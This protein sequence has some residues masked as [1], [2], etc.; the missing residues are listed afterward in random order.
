[1]RCLLFV[2]LLVC[3]SFSSDTTIY[4]NDLPIH[5]EVWINS[6]TD[7]VESL[8]FG[9]DSINFDNKFAIKREAYFDPTLGGS[10]TNASMLFFS[11]SDIEELGY[12]YK[13]DMDTLNHFNMLYNKSDSIWNQSIDFPNSISN[14]DSVTAT[15]I[16]D[17][18]GIKGLGIYYSSDYYGWSTENYESTLLD[19]HRS[20]IYAKLSGNIIIKMQLTDNKTYKYPR[21]YLAGMK[22]SVDMLSDVKLI[23][24][25]AEGSVFP[26]LPNRIK[27]NHD[28]N[29]IRG[30]S[31]QHVNNRYNKYAF[32]AAG[33]LLYK[34]NMFD[35]NIYRKLP[36]QIFFLNII[37]DGKSQFK[38]VNNLIDP[39]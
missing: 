36:Q 37:T 8:D 35:Q 33:R 3:S 24:T 15:D 17:T 23:F 28:S 4:F 16:P 11:G 9:L 34:S 25:I 2:I 32:D 26:L 14:L 5:G 38:R 10:Y 12:K 22:D 21:Q 6:R 31:N 27:G 18:K 20:I 7:F 13:N 39:K 30:I 19:N 1:M 29:A